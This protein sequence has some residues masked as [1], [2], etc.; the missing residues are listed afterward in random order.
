M[1][2][3]T[4]RYGTVWPAIASTREINPG[5]RAFVIKAAE[6]IGHPACRMSKYWKTV[7]LEL[8]REHPRQPLL[9]RVTDA[10]F[11]NQA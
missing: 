4:I 5:S 8:V 1:E 10:A 2:S 11:G 9:G 7:S 6:N 3:G